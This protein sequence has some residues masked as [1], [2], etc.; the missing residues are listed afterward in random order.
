MSDEIREVVESLESL[1]FHAIE[2]SY[3]EYSVI[4]YN[5]N[6]VI[7]LTT[8]YGDVDYYCMDKSGNPISFVVSAVRNFKRTGV[9]Y[10]IVETELIGADLD[11]GYALNGCGHCGHY[12]EQGFINFIL[13]GCAV[14][15]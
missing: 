2:G 11:I 4:L 12:I 13:N 6:Y 15:V 5:D 10:H 14:V 1:G 9:N 8:K 3:E 7:G